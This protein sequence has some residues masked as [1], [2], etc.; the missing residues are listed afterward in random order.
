M[1]SS[2][3]LWPL[4]RSRICRRVGVQ[5]FGCFGERLGHS[6]TANV[7]LFTTA[8]AALGQNRKSSSAR[9]TSALPLKADFAEVARHVRKVPTGDMA[10]SPSAYPEFGIRRR[11]ALA[12]TSE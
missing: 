11:A 6:P 9:V 5:R 10:C 3:S 8:A 7:V 2:T 4:V 12:A 1:E